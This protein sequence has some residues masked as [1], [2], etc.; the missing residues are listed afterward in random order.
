MEE[1]D[2]LP[3][4]KSNRF[5]CENQ[6]YPAEILCDI[7][8]PEGA[9]TLAEYQED[10]YAGTPVLTENSFGKGK[11]YYVGTCSGD[12]FY[13]DFTR[14]LCREQQIVPSAEVMEEV[15]AVRRRGEQAEYLFLLNHGDREQEISIPEQCLELTQG[16]EYR[17]GE[18]VFLPAKG[19]MILRFRR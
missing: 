10:F 17:Q 14:R 3:E 15:E 4:H 13:R 9:E 12:E 2:A 8:H 1:S 18:R 5:I 16:K 19:V 11:A 7:I 6:E